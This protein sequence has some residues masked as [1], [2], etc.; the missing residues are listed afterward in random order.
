[1][2]QSLIQRVLILVPKPAVDVYP[3]SAVILT[4]FYLQCTHWFHILQVTQEVYLISYV[5]TFSGCMKVNKAV[6]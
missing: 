4:E 2:K 5:L 1:M 6:L 3:D